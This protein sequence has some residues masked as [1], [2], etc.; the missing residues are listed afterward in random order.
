MGL[1][2]GRLLTGGG[3][4]LGSAFMNGCFSAALALFIGA[5]AL[6]FTGACSASGDTVGPVEARCR[7][8]CE[9]S[10]VCPSAQGGRPFD[11]Y[12]SCDDLEG[13]NRA[14]E[15]FDEATDYYDCI[16]R[17]GVCSDINTLCIDQQDVYSDCLADPCSTDP[18]RDICS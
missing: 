12:G 5:L 15:C 7:S 1:R 2:W 11:C 16:E 3:S 13:L 6:G 4:V 10:K 18:D 17:R 9:S 8:L 14:N